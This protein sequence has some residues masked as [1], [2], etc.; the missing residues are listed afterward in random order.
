MRGHLEF[1]LGGALLAALLAVA[2][3]G[4]L[5][6]THDP[7]QTNVILKDPDNI[8]E[9]LRDPDTGK[10]IVG[11]KLPPGAHGHV[12]GT[13]ELG[14]DMFSR[15][16]VGL[17]WSISVAFLANVISSFVG[18]G[19]GLLAA[20]YSGPLRTS[21][22]QLIDTMLAL[23]SLVVAIVIVV[24]FGHGFWP[25][26]LT[27]GFL[28]WP[29]FA[30]VTYAEAMSTLQNDYVTAARLAGVG[31]LTILLRHVLPALRSTLLVMGA[32]H[33][34]DLLIAESALSFLGIGAPLSQPTWGNM[35]S[36]A[37][38]HM[39]DA[40]WMLYIPAGAI[41][42][43]VVTANLAGDGLSK[44]LDSSGRQSQL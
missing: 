25:L 44:L 15:L 39:F 35:L 22:N 40:P 17:Q 2:V 21:I 41:I 30:K 43:A 29:I 16:I 19:L 14:R 32:F 6:L 31:R 38:S 36:A 9:F 42:V 33:F 13:D 37:R 5:L 20:E 12:L 8:Q 7:L 1:L 23:P 34:A 18:T 10:P 4:P 3:V 28:T 26:V 27:L 24:L 11:A